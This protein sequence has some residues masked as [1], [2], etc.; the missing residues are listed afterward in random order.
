MN[1]VRLFACV[2]VSIGIAGTPLAQTVPP[3]FHIEIIA[4]VDGPTGLQFP[5]PGSAFG[6][7]LYVGLSN[8]FFTSSPDKILTISPT[9]TIATFATLESEA[10]PFDLL[11]S[12]AASDFGE[13]LFV[14]ANN[15]DGGIPTDCGGVIQRVD[16][17]GNVTDFTAM[18]SPIPCPGGGGGAFL[19]ALGEPTAIERDQRP[20]L[21]RDDRNDIQDHPLGPVVRLAE[22]FD[23]LQ[24]LCEL[25][26]FLQRG[27]GFH[28][29]AQV[30]GELFD[31]DAPQKLLD[32]FCTSR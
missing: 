12:T 25:E 14:A 10:D 32:R 30:L 22:R 3:G 4:T 9:G 28:R 27:L 11:F 6:T 1:V 29:L 19:T 23:D 26:F 15:R 21:G 7:N 8:D 17:V 2:A 24:A 5:P 20:E 13:F 18:T 16:V 31:L